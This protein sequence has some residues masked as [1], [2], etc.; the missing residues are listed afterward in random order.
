MNLLA[1]LLS[2]ATLVLA[3]SAC[4]FG[5]RQPTL[6]YP[7]ASEAGASATASAAASPKRLS[8]LVQPFVDA[9]KDRSKVGTVRNG[10]G[11]PTADVVPTNNVADWF[12]SALRTELQ[13]SGFTVLAAPDAGKT[14]AVLSGQIRNVWA[15]MYFNYNGEIAFDAQV[16]QGG[17]DMLARHYEGNGSAG[18]AW[19]ATAES[20]A[21][22]LAIALANTLKSLI[23]DLDSTAA[24]PAVPR[25]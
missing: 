12:N 11:M 19:G 6:V 2:C 21:Q 23:A 24:A 17:R 18:V 1:K 13:K 15:D 4:A 10:L 20:Y 16:K 14:F 5:T 8:I 3:L 22:T 9:R 25:N 7:P